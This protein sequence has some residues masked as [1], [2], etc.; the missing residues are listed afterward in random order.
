MFF[1]FSLCLCLSLFAFQNPPTLAL[2]FTYICLQNPET[3]AFVHDT[4]RPGYGRTSFQ[5]TVQSDRTNM[6]PNIQL[7]VGWVAQSV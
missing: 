7:A 5:V 3:S 6:G 4:D 1:F 2:P